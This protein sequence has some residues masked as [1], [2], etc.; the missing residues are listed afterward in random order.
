M[1]G[2]AAT[3]RNREHVRIRSDKVIMRGCKHSEGHARLGCEL[4][5]CTSDA[6]RLLRTA[7]H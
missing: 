1:I 7:F 2:I 6:G 3:A 4:G 5:H